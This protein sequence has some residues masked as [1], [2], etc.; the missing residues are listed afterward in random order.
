[1]SSWSSTSSTIEA[2]SGMPLADFDFGTSIRPRPQ[3]RTVIRSPPNYT[4]AS[5]STHRSIVMS[6]IPMHSAISSYKPMICRTQP[7]PRNTTTGKP[8]GLPKSDKLTV[9]GLPREACGDRVRRRSVVKRVE[10]KYWAMV[11]EGELTGTF[12]RP[13]K[14]RG[15]RGGWSEIVVEYE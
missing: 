14:S 13:I 7:K 6:L 12:V 5:I 1:M 2:H 15:G 10:R 4:G 11:C 9:S 8:V 3:L